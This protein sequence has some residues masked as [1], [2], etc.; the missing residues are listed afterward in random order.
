MFLDLSLVSRHC[1]YSVSP[2]DSV[3]VCCWGWWVFQFPQSLEIARLAGQAPHSWPLRSRTAASPGEISCRSRYLF[4]SKWLDPELMSA[5]VVL[6][7]QKISSK[8][9]DCATDCD[10]IETM[11]HFSL[12][13][14]SIKSENKQRKPH[15]NM[16]TLW[17]LI[18]R[19][20]EE[21]SVLP[22]WA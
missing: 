6:R 3:C 12:V 15:F 2:W 8:S 20:L 13:T 1:A 11:T 5:L 14:N 9:A 10:G 16:L 19:G 22:I 18:D 21:V 4:I 17:A 7:S